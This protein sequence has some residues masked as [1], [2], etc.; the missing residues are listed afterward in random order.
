MTDQDSITEQSERPLLRV[1]E[2]WDGQLIL[3]HLTIFRLLHVYA[4]WRVRFSPE[5]KHNS[6]Q[7]RSK[8]EEDFLDDMHTVL[9]IV[10]D[11]FPNPH[12]FSDYHFKLGFISAVYHM[13]HTRL[14]GE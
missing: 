4:M 3:N 13:I 14:Y 5:P 12:G 11:S 1:V 6:K 10:A 9:E 7:A 2:W 8:F